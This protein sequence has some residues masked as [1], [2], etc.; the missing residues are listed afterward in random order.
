MKNTIKHRI[1]KASRA[2]AVLLLIFSFGFKESIAQREIYPWEPEFDSSCLNQSLLD[3]SSLTKSMMFGFPSFGDRTDYIFDNFYSEYNLINNIDTVLYIYKKNK[4]IICKYIYNKGYIIESYIYGSIF[5]RDKKY[6]L[7]ANYIHTVYSYSK[8]DKGLIVSFHRRIYPDNINNIRTTDSLL[9]MFDTNHKIDSFFRKYKEVSTYKKYIY[10]N[11]LLNGFFMNIMHGIYY[12]NRND[13]LKNVDVY[14]DYQTINN[15]EIRLK[16]KDILRKGMVSSAELQ[17]LFDTLKS[18]LF[19]MDIYTDE[20]IIDK[21]HTESFYLPYPDLHVINRTLVYY[22]TQKNQVQYYVEG[23][24]DSRNNTHYSPNS[25]YFRNHYIDC[26][27]KKGDSY[28]MNQLLFKN[29]VLLTYDVDCCYATGGNKISMK[30]KSKNEIIYSNIKLDGSRM[31]EEFS[32][33]VTNTKKSRKLIY[34]I[35]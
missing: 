12:S 21:K 2:F 8:N 15:A 32:I 18:S 35:Q 23:K 11:N 34:Y 16:Y 25:V 3:F 24:F 27:Y 10:K 22:N 4:N 33:T 30:K 6:S 5:N 19:V 17:V 31:E 1:G 13:S 29:P 9:L 20:N 14:V 28:E 7:F 26:R